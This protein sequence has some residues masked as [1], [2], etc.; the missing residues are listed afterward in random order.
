MQQSLYS[1]YWYRIAG[2]KPRL[3]GHV[4][5]HRHH[6]RGRLWYLI[7]DHSSGRFHRFTEDAYAVVSLLDGRHSLDDIWTLMVRRYGEGV[8]RQDDIVQLIAKLYRADALVMDAPPNTAELFDRATRTRGKMRMMRWRSPLSIRV[9]LLD[10][11]AFLDR[12]VRFVRPLFSPFG[13]LLWLATVISAVVLAGIHWEALTDNVVD[14]VLGSGNLLILLLT[15]PLVKVFHEFGHAYATRAMGGEVHEMGVIFL[16]LMPVPYC[17]A[18]SASAFSERHKRVVVGAA[19]MI[20][21]LFIASLAMWIWAGAEPGLVRA[22]AFNVMIIAGISTL[23]FNGNPLIRFDGYYILSDLVE[24]PN[25]AVRSNQYFGYLIQRYLF[26]VKGQDSPASGPGEARWLFGY[27]VG[28]FFYRIFL[29][30]VIVLFL[31][32]KFFVIGI[33]LAAWAFVLMAVLPLWR[34]LMF[35]V[36]NPRLRGSRARAIAVSAAAVAG[37]AW[38]AMLPLPLATLVEGVVWVPESARVRMQTEGFV[39]RVAVADGQRVNAGQVLVVSVNPAL[40]A[41]ADVLEARLAELTAQMESYQ[42]QDLVQLEL[43]REQVQTVGAQ[44]DSL[45]AELDAL[46]LRSHADGVF[47]LG[48][49]R[50]LV[51]RFL[52]RGAMVGFVNTPG[53]AV[54]RVVVPQSSVDLVRSDTRAVAIR[55]AHDTTRVFDAFIQREVPSASD[56]IPSLVLATEGGGTIAMDPRQ[57]DAPTAFE[58]LFQFDVAFDPAA[59]VQR[60][61]ERVYVR[62]DHGEE[63]LARQ[64][65]R[66]VR[67]VFLRRFDV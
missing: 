4:Q 67:Q 39:D 27:A 55:M 60:F 25:L 44:L 38:L 48:D 66:Q 46:V 52:P 8:M 3:R 24:I 1:P 51:G 15:F 26:G 62:F 11:G 63:A 35:L 40:S 19:G 18:S 9:P 56:A 10:P 14:R 45:R 29:T 21:E 17:E 42:R 28:S 50:E 23:L 12:T 37:L 13:A 49:A 65:Y 34:Q 53:D 33:L 61:G 6:Y 57:G 36:K 22:V 5:I 2:L 47:H 54:A 43:A 41:R 59:A 32:E 30:I 31:A 58:A 64:V 20:V 16:V 7:Q